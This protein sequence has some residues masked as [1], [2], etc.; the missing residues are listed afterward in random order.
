MFFSLMR[1]LEI[2]QN[3]AIIGQA[4]SQHPG[5]FKFPQNLDGLFQKDHGCFIFLHPAIK[6]TYVGETVGLTM[7]VTNGMIKSKSRIKKVISLGIIAQAALDLTQPQLSGG[8][9]SPVAN[10]AVEL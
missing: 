6:K 9:S 4:F 5:V 10:P 7:P 8:F 2:V 3:P 1:L